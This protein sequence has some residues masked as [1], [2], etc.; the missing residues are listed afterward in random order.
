MNT[1]TPGFTTV[2]LGRPWCRAIQI[3]D[4]RRLLMRPIQPSD[5]EM[6]QRSFQTLTPQEVRMRFMHQ[7]TGL[8]D[9]FARRLCDVDPVRAFAVVLV[10]VKP[11][12]VALIRAV[13]R[14][15]MDDDGEEA[16]FAIIVG[17][18]IRRLGFGQYLMQQLI[19][20][21]RAR[22]LTAIYGFILEENQPML[23]LME[24]MGFTLGPS[25]DDTGVVL[26]HMRLS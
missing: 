15:A 17:R 18:E 9:D 1:A 2:A 23:A 25:D 7:M 5:A 6:L 13:A 24:R 20:W 3:A 19:D 16:E 21:S 10:E 8:T 26:A 12:E 22:G 11:P 14:V 4:G